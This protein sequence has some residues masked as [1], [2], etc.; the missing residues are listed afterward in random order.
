MS[1]VGALI[2][3]DSVGVAKEH[4]G[5]VSTEGA[6]EDGGLGPEEVIERCAGCVQSVTTCLRA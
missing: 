1:A 4:V 6:D 3:G 2:H 5:V